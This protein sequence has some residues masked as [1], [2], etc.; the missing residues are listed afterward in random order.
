VV[1]SLGFIVNVYLLPAQPTV[2]VELW[3]GVNEPNLHVADGQTDGMGMVQF[4]P[5]SSYYPLNVQARA[6]SLGL[7]S[8]T[9]Q[10]IDG[11][12]ITLNLE[13]P[14]NGG[15]NGGVPVVEIPEVALPLGAI[16][17]G[18]LIAR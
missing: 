6:P 3:V 1:T 17:L 16:L 9:K 4:R 8:E 11:S 2:D 7:T 13:G 14:S 15:G 5:G 18:L 12:T 10:V